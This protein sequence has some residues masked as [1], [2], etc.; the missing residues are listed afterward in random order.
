MLSYAGLM[1]KSLLS[2][3]PGLRPALGWTPDVG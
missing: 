1:Q 3:K 2:K